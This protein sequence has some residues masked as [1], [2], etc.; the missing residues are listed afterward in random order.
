MAFEY[1]DTRL[2]INAI[3]KNTILPKELQVHS[4]SC[5][6]TKVLVYTLF[7]MYINGLQP[8][9]SIKV[10]LNPFTQSLTFILT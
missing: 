1:A 10:F 2:R 8:L 4:K 7:F 6:F 9:N 5:S 3:R